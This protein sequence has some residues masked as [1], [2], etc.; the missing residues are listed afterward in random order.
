MKAALNGVPS[1]SVLDGWLIEGCI[2]GA[3]GW[4]IGESP[5]VAE[6][7]EAEAV[8]MYSKLEQKILPLYYGRRSAFAEVM[9]NAIAINGSFF[10]AQRMVSQY[11][12]IAWSG[13]AK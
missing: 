8:S 7:D 9:R 2:E 6:S 3:T 10:N 12:S 4:A 11:V 1:L 5:E 13:G